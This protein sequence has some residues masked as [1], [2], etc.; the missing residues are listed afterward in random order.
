MFMITDLLQETAGSLSRNRAR[1]ALTG[2][3]VAWGIFM[4]IVLLGVARGVVNSFEGDVSD[5]NFESLTVWGGTTVYPYR[6]YQPG[7]R[8]TLH[9][10]DAELITGQNS[11]YVASAE[12]SVTLIDAALST[13]LG[14]SGGTLTGVTP[15]SVGRSEIRIVR[16][17]FINESDMSG[18]RKV[19]VIPARMA[20]V[21]FGDESAAVGGYVSAKGLSW[22]VAGVYD[23]RWRN[24]VYVPY[25]TARALTGGRRDVDKI[26]VRGKDLN[27]KADARAIEEGV[28]ATLA[29]AH[30][31]DRREGGSGALWIWNQ[32]ESYLSTQEAMAILVRAVWIIGVLTLL[33]GIVGISN[34]M[35][36]SVRERTHEIGIRR[37]IGARPSSIL[38]SV[39]VE[40]ISIAVL[41]GYAGV[42]AGMGVLEIVRRLT[43]DT[44]V[45]RDPSISTVMA[46]E[47]TLLLALSGALAGLFPAIKATKIHPVEALRNE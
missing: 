21:L 47:V 2:L 32:F 25:T 44:G 31:F 39:I 26:T 20:R 45:L 28:V 41:S 24:D 5:R 40:S 46:L 18:S 17:R 12:V 34:I 33:T 1:T 6:G 27:N 30:S 11:R 23:N 22:L 29:S 7:R 42:I 10:T 14:T 19:V 13:P 8:I 15:A 35:F 4:L 36:V 43:A 9:D 16:G 38:T 37:A 3:A